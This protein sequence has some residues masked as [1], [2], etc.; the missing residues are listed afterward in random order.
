MKG[1]R[2]GPY[3]VGPEVLHPF[4]SMLEIS[5][6]ILQIY[7]EPRDRRFAVGGGIVETARRACAVA[8]TDAAHLV[9]AP[10]ELEG[11]L[12][13]AAEAIVQQIFRHVL[14]LSQNENAHEDRKSTRLN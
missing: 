5:A 9:S 6:D 12:S 2:P 1:V 4:T 14:A 11:Q 13:I 3:H 10:G 7:G 8:E